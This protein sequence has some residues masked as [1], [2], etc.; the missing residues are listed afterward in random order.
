[1]PELMNSAHYQGQ[2]VCTAHY[3]YISMLLPDLNLQISFQTVWVCMDVL[4]QTPS[5]HLKIL[6]NTKFKCFV[7]LHKA[8]KI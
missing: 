3:L 5:K 8:L 4:L 2:K 1:V 6:E 7:T